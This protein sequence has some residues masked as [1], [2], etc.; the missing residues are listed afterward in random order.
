MTAALQTPY[1]GDYTVEKFACDS[2][3]M[4]FDSVAGLVRHYRDRHPEMIEKVTI[5]I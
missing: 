4:K 3:P 1:G 2:C 5:P